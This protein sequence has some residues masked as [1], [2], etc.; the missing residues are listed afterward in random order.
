MG[1]GSTRTPGR[2]WYHNRH[3]ART[4]SRKA[5]PARYRHDIWLWH[6]L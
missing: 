1:R 6:A 2:N 3:T 5:G 4:V